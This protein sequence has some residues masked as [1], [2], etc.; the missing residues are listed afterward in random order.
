[1]SNKNIC[2]NYFLS[3]GYIF[4]E[5]KKLN[6]YLSYKFMVFS[7]NKDLIGV[8]LLK[9]EEAIHYLLDIA[10]IANMLKPHL[11]ICICV[12]K[13]SLFP[14]DINQKI[15]NSNIEIY[16][17]EGRSLDL[18]SSPL[19]LRVMQVYKSNEIGRLLRSIN[20]L[21]KKKCDSL[22][23]KIN[24]GDLKKI[25]LQTLTKS[26]FIM[27]ISQISTILEHLEYKKMEDSL[28]KLTKEEKVPFEKNQSIS[29]L[30]TFL[31]KNKIKISPTLKQSFK[32]FRD[33][34]DL[35]N[36]PPIHRSDKYKK[37]CLKYIGK[38]PNKEVEWKSLNKIVLS[39]F[40]GGLISLRDSLK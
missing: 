13:D 22:I 24:A 23:F 15:Y 31:N 11:K 28:I 32:D 34:R 5:E 33:L 6:K 4:S 10:K 19:N 30:E 18:F 17:I 9:K 3:L 2:K 39:K 38:I 26:D 25:K 12:P 27:Q 21:S 16:V 1:M 8:C 29:A 36:M 20:W 14:A 37:V 7:K 35:R 40:E